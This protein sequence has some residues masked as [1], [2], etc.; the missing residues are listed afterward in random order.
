MAG[1]FLERW[2]WRGEPTADVRAAVAEL[3]RFAA[4]RPPFAAPA[5]LMRDLL[6]LLF[7]QTDAPQLP[8]L[9]RE[10]ARTKL[11][12]GVPL[13]REEALTLDGRAFGKRWQIV[14]VTLQRHG[15]VAAEPL[16]EA[17]RQ[18]A[19]DGD[20]L[21]RAVLMGRPEDVYARAE[22]LDLEAPLMAT[23]LRLTLFPT[24]A[25]VSAA[26]APLR[27]GSTWN[28]GHCPACGSWPLLAELRGLEPT[29]WLRC[30][31][32][33]TGWEAERLLC[34][35]CGCR[36]HAALGYFHVEGN[37]Q[38]RVTTCDDCRGYLK[39]VTTLTPRSAPGLLALDAATLDLDLAASQRG[40]LCPG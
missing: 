26:L 15:N 22:L 25:A 5:L 38:R 7:A 27:H 36:D 4:E 40:Y 31:L 12:A 13:L 1:A 8:A 14:C 30:G 32:C 34:P 29:R 17:L 16:T 18:G 6:P 10:S 21:V 39:A 19:L 3:E 11:A 20:E 23:A 9:T 33:A 24:L 37:G 35:F 28:G 2:F